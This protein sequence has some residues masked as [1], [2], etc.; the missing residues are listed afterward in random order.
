MTEP[1]DCS[2]VTAL[3]SW[4][5]TAQKSV[6]NDYGLLRHVAVRARLLTA[7]PGVGIEPTC[8]AVRGV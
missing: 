5:D 3:D 2:D 7:V 8:L 6:H 4:L 1:V